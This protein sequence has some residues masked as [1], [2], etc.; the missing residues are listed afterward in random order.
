MKPNEWTPGSMVRVG[1]LTL[2]VVRK[3]PE[4]RVDDGRP[5]PWLLEGSKGRTYLFTPYNGLER[6]S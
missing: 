3:A 5:V 6:V 1:F 4:R 2:T